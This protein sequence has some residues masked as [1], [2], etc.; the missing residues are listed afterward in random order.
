[1]LSM[2]LGVVLIGFGLSVL[3]WVFNPD[4]MRA[5]FHRGRHTQRAQARRARREADPVWRSEE[6]FREWKKQYP[7]LMD[8]TAV[9]PRV[10]LTR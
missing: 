2:L 8:E 6:W 7:A 4:A 5:Y 9:M 3:L 10:Q 1:M